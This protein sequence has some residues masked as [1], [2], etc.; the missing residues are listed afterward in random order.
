MLIDE[1]QVTDDERQVTEDE[2]NSD[3]VTSLKRN[4]GS[5]FSCMIRDAK[6]LGLAL[7]VP[8]LDG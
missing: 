2:A 4:M 7:G 6:A 8:C 3:K 1:R 5:D